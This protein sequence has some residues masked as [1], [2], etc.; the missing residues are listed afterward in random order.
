[1]CSVS[2][3]YRCRGAGLPTL[4]G[5]YVFG[6]YCAKKIWIGLKS[7]SGSWSSADLIPT[8]FNISTFGEDSSGEIYVADLKRPIYR[9]ARVPYGATYQASTFSTTTN[10]S[11]TVPVTVTNTGSLTW[12]ANSPFRLAYH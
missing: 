8:G 10:A 7:A 3:W 5:A 12:D 9:L 11:L 4:N 6:D 1:G 2:G